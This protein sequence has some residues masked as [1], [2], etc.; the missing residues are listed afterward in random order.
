MSTM[1]GKVNSSYETRTYI[2]WY[3]NGQMKAKSI[4][5]VARGKILEYT[6]WDQSGKI[7]DQE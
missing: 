5:G 4:R 3:D 6:E 2:E 7:I 1:G